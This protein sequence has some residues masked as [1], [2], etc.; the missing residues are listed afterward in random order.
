MDLRRALTEAILSANSDAIIAAD[1][2]GV[3]V[4]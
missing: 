2:E 4:F 1:N 3:I